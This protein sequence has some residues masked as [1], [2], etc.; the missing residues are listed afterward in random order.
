MPFDL[1]FN[2]ISIFNGSAA[3]TVVARVVPLLGSPPCFGHHGARGHVP[4]GA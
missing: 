1:F 4:N 3:V 2:P